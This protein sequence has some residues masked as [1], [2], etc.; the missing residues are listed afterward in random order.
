MK[1]VL[2]LSS[3]FAQAPC[4][5]QQFSLGDLVG[6]VNDVEVFEKKESGSR[7]SDH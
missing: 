7:K 6:M 2:I 1:Y 5:A 3:I 4:F